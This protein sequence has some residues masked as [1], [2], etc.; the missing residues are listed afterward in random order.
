MDYSCSLGRPLF[1]Q[2]SSALCPGQGCELRVSDSQCSL[3][4]GQQRLRLS[5]GEEPLR[6]VS[7]GQTPAQGHHPRSP[8]GA[9]IPLGWGSTGACVQGPDSYMRAGARL[10]PTTG[11][12][13]KA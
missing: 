13:G 2:K 12:S 3:P 10:L 6:F 9:R 7:R 11:V 4:K 8:D 1:Q 5:G